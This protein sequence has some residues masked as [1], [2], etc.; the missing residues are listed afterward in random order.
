MQARTPR[1]RR[2]GSSYGPA[3][4]ELTCL[5]LLGCRVVGP[6]ALS[7]PAQRRAERA[8]RAFEAGLVRHILACG[9]KTW[10]SVREADALCAYLAKR[11]IPEHALERELWSH[12]TR[13]NAHYAAQLLQPRG[14]RRVALVTCDWHMPRALRC[15][16]RAGFETEP[17]PAISPQANFRERCWR[18]LR[19]RLSLTLDQL[20]T[21]DFSRL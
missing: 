3:T 17:V 15:F 21:R 2:D 9:G 11:G 18:A 5:V 10:G 1:T 16:R 6:R 19:E 4:V 7:A 12:S 20:A 8:A 13:E 14:I